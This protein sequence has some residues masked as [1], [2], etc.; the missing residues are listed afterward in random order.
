VKSCPSALHF[1]SAE[2]KA[3]KALRKKL[4]LKLVALFGSSFITFR[5]EK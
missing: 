4:V 3:D 2:L 1:A 5:I